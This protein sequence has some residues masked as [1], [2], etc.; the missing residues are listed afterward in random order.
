MIRVVD[1]RDEALGTFKA[2]HAREPK[3]E[4]E[5]DFTWPTKWQEVGEG[6]AVMYRSNK[7]KKDLRSHEDYKHVAEGP[8]ALLVVPGYLRER[9]DESVH[10]DAFGPYFTLTGPMPQHFTKLG[11][12][13]GVQARLYDEKDNGDLYLPNGDD[14]LYQ[15]EMP[16]C[17]LGGA[18]HPESD[19][20]FLFFYDKHGIY[21]MITGAELDIEK[22][23]IVG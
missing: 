4:T 14:R 6:K 7:W 22:D 11:P 1:T 13:L 10:I 12:V 19:E 20:P 17:H 3:R 9:E 15:I 2:F 23:G 8:Q 5:F 16:R 21:M 18:K